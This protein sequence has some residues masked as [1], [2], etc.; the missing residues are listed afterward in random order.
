MVSIPQNK[1]RSSS[2]QSQLGNDSFFSML[3]VVWLHTEKADS[4][5]HRHLLLDESTAYCEKNLYSYKQ[6]IQWFSQRLY[7]TDSSHKGIRSF[8]RTSYEDTGTRN[9]ILYP[10]CACLKVIRG[11]IHLTGPHVKQ[12]TGTLPILAST[13][14]TVIQKKHT[15]SWELNNYMDKLHMKRTYFRSD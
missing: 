10:L 12:W 3:Q 1:K 15:S 13:H 4:F 7:Y 14:I 5:L 2:A 9:T 11:F 8:S 6:L